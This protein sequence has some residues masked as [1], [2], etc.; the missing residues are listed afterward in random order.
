MSRPAR[1]LVWDTAAVATDLAAALRDLAV[2]EAV[3]GRPV[4]EIEARLRLAPADVLHIVAPDDGS[5]LP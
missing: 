3:T 4:G 2:I 5:D 1:V